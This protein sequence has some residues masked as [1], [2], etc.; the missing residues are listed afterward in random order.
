MFGVDYEIDMRFMYYD[1]EG[2]CSLDV[3]VEEVCIFFMELVFGFLGVNIVFVSYGGSI[4]CVSD[5]CLLEG[6]IGIVW[7]DGDGSVIVVG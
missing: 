6:E 2:G 5:L 1:L 3:V 7:L 4:F